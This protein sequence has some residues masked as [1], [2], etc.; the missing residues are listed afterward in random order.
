MGSLVK[1][2]VDGMERGMGGRQGRTRPGKEK[3]VDLWAE[4]MSGKE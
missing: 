3:T 4:S 1:V 2:Y